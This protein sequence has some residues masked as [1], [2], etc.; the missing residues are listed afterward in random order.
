MGYNKVVVN[1]VTKIDLTGDT[2]TSSSILAGVTA[3]NSAGNKIVGQIQEQNE[4]SITET[5]SGDVVIPSGYYSSPIIYTPEQKPLGLVSL[6]TY[7]EANV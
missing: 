3:H 6:V 2:V 5:E 1:G 4:N 7:N